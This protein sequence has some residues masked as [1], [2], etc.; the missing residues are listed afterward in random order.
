M[1]SPAWIV[2]AVGKHFRGLVGAVEVRVAP[3]YG[4]R[5]VAHGSIHVQ[6]EH[7][8][9]E[10]AEESEDNVSAFRFCYVLRLHSI[11]GSCPMAKKPPP[12]PHLRQ[13]Y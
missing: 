2:E 5:H 10:V 1:F 13:N 6:T 11:Q 4:I 7:G 3:G 9:C 12:V 8:T